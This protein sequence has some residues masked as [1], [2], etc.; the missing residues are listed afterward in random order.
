MLDAVHR[1]LIQEHGGAYGVR[2]EHLIESALARPRNRF[3][4]EQDVDLADL[5]AAY[6]FGLTKNHGYVDGN[7]RIGLAAMHVFARLNGTRLQVGEPEEVA[8]M[9]QVADG[10]LSESQLAAWVRQHFAA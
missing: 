3:A 1:E 5:V 2:D 8:V 4:Y 7:K 6:G 10:S 9:L